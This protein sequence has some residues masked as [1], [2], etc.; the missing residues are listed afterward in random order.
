MRSGEKE[1]SQKLSARCG[2]TYVLLVNSASRRMAMIKAHQLALGGLKR[3]SEGEIIP[4]LIHL[5]I[6]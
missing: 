4:V 1:R 6:K 5:E 2:L 3:R